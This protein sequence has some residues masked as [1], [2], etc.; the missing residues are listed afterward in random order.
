MAVELF[1]AAGLRATIALLAPAVLGA[2]PRHVEFIYADGRGPTRMD[3]AVRGHA[4]AR[5][6]LDIACWDLFGKATG[7]R[8]SGLLGGTHQEEFPLYTGIG[9]AE[10]AEMRRRAEDA[11]AAGSSTRA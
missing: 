10:P 8:V 6:A 4:H 5:S 2:D 7:M 9:V 11:L 3:A 1:D